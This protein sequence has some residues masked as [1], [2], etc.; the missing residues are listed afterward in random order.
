MSIHGGQY[1]W[2]IGQAWGQD[3]AMMTK[4]LFCMLM[5]QAEGKV[6]KHAKK[7]EWTERA[8]PIQ[9]LLDLL[10]KNATQVMGNP[11]LAR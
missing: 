7:R 11:E 8:W 1:I 3:R 5:D 9:G 2:V 10:W 4:F 6:H